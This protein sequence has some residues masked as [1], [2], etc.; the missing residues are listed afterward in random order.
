MKKMEIRDI[1][2]IGLDILKSIHLFCVSN[3]INYSVYGG[4]LIGMIRHQGFIPWDDDIDIAMPRPDYDR[5]IRTYHDSDNGYHL[6]CYELGNSF[7][8]YARV[9]EMKKTVVSSVNL[10]WT[11]SETGVWVDV[12]PLDGAADD[13]NQAEQKVAYLKRELEH[14]NDFRLSKGTSFFQKTNWH[15]RKRYLLS[16]LFFLRNRRINPE[17]ICPGIIASCKEIEFGSTDHFCNYS[18]VNFG[19][20]EYHPVNQFAELLS[21]PFE[22]TSFHCIS[23]YDEHLKHKYGDYMILPPE[24]MRKGHGGYSFYWK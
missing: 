12:F 23:K 19:M 21:L 10:P 17:S 15:Y 22:D 5:F 7:L 1:Q 11:E 14:L 2:S 20:R 8:P 3:D 18:Y 13:Y 6:F 4:T 24:D 9:C 16:K